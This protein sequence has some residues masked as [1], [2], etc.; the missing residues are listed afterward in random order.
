MEVVGLLRS[1][2]ALACVL[3]LLAGALWT[4]RRF[5]LKLPG[6]V[7][8]AGRDDRRLG[9]VERVQLDQKRSVVLVRRDDREHLFVLTPD[10]VTVLEAGIATGTEPSPLPAPAAP[11]A[12]PPARPAAPTPFRDLVAC[13]LNRDWYRG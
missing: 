10:R 8:G 2:G 13:D 6:R 9:I 1:L 11:R 3:G 7:G 12:L 5:D 4:V